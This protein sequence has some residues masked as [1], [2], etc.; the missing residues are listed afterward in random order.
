MSTIQCPICDRIDQ[1]QR[2]T[3]IVEGETHDTTGSGE[4]IGGS[5]IEGNTDH[6]LGR[7][8]DRERVGD[9]RLSAS[10]INYS[11][12]RFNV[13]QQS[14]LANKLARPALPAKP[15]YSL[16]P[17]LQ[18]LVSFLAV[19]PAFLVWVLTAN[20]A[21]SLDVGFFV[22]VLLLFASIIPPT[23]AWVI[24]SDL[25]EKA[26]LHNQ[27][28]AQERQRALTQ[29]DYESKRWEVASK[30]WNAMYYCRRCDVVYVPGD[31]FAPV[32]PE[33]TITLAYAGA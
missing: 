13:T 25:L 26:I 28:P 8:F 10:S 24:V 19:I 23:I 1:A 9:S 16:S 4:T 2:V 5:H 18:K 17:I 21:Q 33:N 11:T 20:L 31:T 15:D 27:Y 22:D 30:R 6:Y 3:A 29:Y 7:G 12:T 32:S 14:R